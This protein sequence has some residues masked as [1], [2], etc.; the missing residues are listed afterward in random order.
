MT[1]GYIKFNCEWTRKELS[2]TEDLFERLNKS[3]SILYGSGLI[4]A[5]PGGIGFGNISVKTGNVSFVITGSSTGQF[6]M[7]NQSHY[8]LVTSYSFT[9]NSVS[10]TGLTKASAESLTHAALYEALPGV[11][12]VAHVHCLW[13]W[14]KLLGKF[15][16]TSPEIEYGTA[17]MAK[18]VQSLATD[19]NSD[20]EKLIIMGGHREGIL[21]FGENIEEATDQIIQI[22]NRFK[23]D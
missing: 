4:G 19:L 1:E 6:A 17:E 2:V 7:L 9:E 21:S 12:A 15:A 14:E 16:T 8:A 3:R 20:G 22:Y 11:K 23:N 5:Y 13:L 18:E 10:C